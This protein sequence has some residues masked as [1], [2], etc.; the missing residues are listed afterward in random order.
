[1]GFSVLTD[2][3]YSN[4]HYTRLSTERQRFDKL[5]GPGAQG[6][7][8]LC[9]DVPRH[10]PRCHQLLNGGSSRKPVSLNRPVFGDVFSCPSKLQ[11]HVF[12]VFLSAFTAAIYLLRPAHA[13]AVLRSARATFKPG[14]RL[15]SRQRSGSPKREILGNLAHGCGWRAS[16]GNGIQAASRC[17]IRSHAVAG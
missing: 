2:I 16:A 12:P 6:S 13:R 14:I 17:E 5:C 11:S 8:T 7:G 9:T 1:M 3:E 15:L 4:T 10:L